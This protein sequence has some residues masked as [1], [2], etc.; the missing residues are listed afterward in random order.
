MAGQKLKQLKCSS[1]SQLFGPAAFSPLSRQGPGSAP[2]AWLQEAEVPRCAPEVPPPQLRGPAAIRLDALSFPIII[3]Q[4]CHR[5]LSP[6]CISLT[7]Y[8]T[9]SNL[10]FLI[11]WPCHPRWSLRI[12]G[13]GAVSLLNSYVFGYLMLV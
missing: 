6:P 7:E 4:S 11:I 13:L 9:N 5:L 12:S 8:Q 3:L 1:L 2:R 10:I